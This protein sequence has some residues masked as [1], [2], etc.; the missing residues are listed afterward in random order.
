MVVAEQA[1]A[2]LCIVES[3]AAGGAALARY[4]SMLE[5]VAPK[6]REGRELNPRASRLPDGLEVAIAGGLMWLVHQRLIAG[7]VDELK[8]LLPEML[9]VT[10]DALRRGGR[11]GARRGGGAGPGG[12]LVAAA[13]R[14][15]SA[16]SGPGRCERRPRRGRDP[17]RE[18]IAAAMVEMVADH[19]FA[20][21]DVAAVCERAEVGRAHFDRCFAD[22]ED[23][24]L[25]LHDEVVEE[26]CGR[27]DAAC[28]GRRGL[29]RPDLGGGH[30]GDALPAGGLRPRPLPRRRRQRR[31]QRRPVAPRP[32]RA[33]DRRL[34]RRRPRRGRAASGRCPAARPKSPPAP[35]TARS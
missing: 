31:R 29:A 11:G 19:G 7:R 14:R 24:F 16:G 4:Q 21:V 8:G 22:L 15:R 32:D 18:R 28:D 17:A 35:S 10:L 3:Q 20:A 30:G 1:R 23:C 34:A 5:S 12:G 6:L 25:G 27:V 33:A 2:K 26:L 13:G 9:Q